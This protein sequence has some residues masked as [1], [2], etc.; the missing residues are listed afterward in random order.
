M[1]ITGHIELFLRSTSMFILM[2]VGL[3]R[4]VAIYSPMLFKFI[5]SLRVISVFLGLA[6][7]YGA[8]VVFF[9]RPQGIRF[10]Q[11]RFFVY[12][13]DFY[14]TP[15]DFQHP[16]V[17]LTLVSGPVLMAAIFYFTAGLKLVWQKITA[18]GSAQSAAAASTEPETATV[19]QERAQNDMVR[20]AVILFVL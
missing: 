11:P 18:G 2:E 14:S 4:A 12:C 6:P 13:L 17:T 5:F 8:T 10:F 9:L 19:A 7:V 15:D 16:L 20:L 3:T 1:R